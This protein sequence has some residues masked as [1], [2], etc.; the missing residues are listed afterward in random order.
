[1]NKKQI[2]PLLGILALLVIIPVATSYFMRNGFELRIAALQDDEPANVVVTD[3]TSNS[4]RVSWITEREVI[5]A[6]ELSDG[7]TFSES[8][9]TSYHVVNVVGLQSSTDYKF[10]L[11]SG[12][13]D[14]E[15]EYSQSTAQAVL[16][17]EQFPIYGQVFSADGFSFQQGGIITLSL[18]TGSTQSQA[19]STSINET[20]GYQFDLGKL[21]TADL[22]SKFPYQEEATATL[23]IYT[24][25]E[26]EG[27]EKMTPVDFSMNRQM[28]N[29]Y[30]GEVNIDVIPG[31][32]GN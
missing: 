17:D 12:A 11:S 32:E 27:I 7:A 1:M 24:S 3:A 16:S 13:K 15:E 28:Q 29:I 2:L 22:K 8:D 5:G 30:L 31:I 10:S 19:L 25:H 23:T 20:G 14:F 26:Q 21:H 6:V 18:D 4:F 9:S